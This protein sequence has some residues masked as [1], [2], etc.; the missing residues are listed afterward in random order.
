[1]EGLLPL[2]C[3]SVCKYADMC[4]AI[5]NCPADRLRAVNYCSAVVTGSCCLA[6]I[7]DKAGNW[8]KGVILDVGS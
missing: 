6:P 5:D 2:F 7:P 3:L 8:D 1:M 4:D